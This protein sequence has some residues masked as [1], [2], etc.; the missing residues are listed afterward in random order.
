[1]SAGTGRALEVT[2]LS[3]HIE[4]TRSTVQAVGKAPYAK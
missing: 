3:T 1:M 4:L 2:N